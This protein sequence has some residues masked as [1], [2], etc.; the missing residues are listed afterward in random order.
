MKL[1]K[2]SNLVFVV[3]A[4]GALLACQNEQNST[5]GD[6]GLG[7]DNTVISDEPTDVSDESLA[8]PTAKSTSMP[9]LIVFPLS[10]RSGPRTQT[11][12]TVPH[13]QIGV[14][15]VAAVNDELFRR[16]F[17]LPGVV[18]R[19]TIVSLPGARGMWLS[20]DIALAHPEA[21]V[22]GREFAHIHPDGS[23]H[24][25]LPYERALEVAEKGWGERHPWADERAGWDGL[26]MLFTPQSMEE[27]EITFQLIVESYN[28]VT[29][30]T[31]Q[32]S[33]FE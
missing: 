10:E 6:N 15:S 26:V 5:V 9:D 11:S 4:L 22:A 33:D 13:V 20:D 24:A 18:D 8:V 16:A 17:A 14:E 30:Q 21:I 29:G 32:A 2:I 12:G 19:P 25:P 7:D 27:L 28:F 23:L 1:K 31:V 3:M